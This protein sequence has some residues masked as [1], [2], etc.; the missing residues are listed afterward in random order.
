MATTSILN[1]KDNIRPTSWV[2]WGEEGEAFDTSDGHYAQTDEVRVFD[3]IEDIEVEF[4]LNG[5]FLLPNGKYVPF[6]IGYSEE[7]DGDVVIPI[8]K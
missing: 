2:S 3:S 6:Q 7:E 8:W 5:V 1:W 4:P